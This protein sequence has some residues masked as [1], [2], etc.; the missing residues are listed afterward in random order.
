MSHVDLHLHLLPGVDDGART[1]AESVTHARRMAAGGVTEATV[2][3]HVHPAWPLDL[4]SLPGRVAA[5]REALAAE[6]VPLTLH[7]GGEVDARHAAR[8]GHEDL[9]RVAHGPPGRRW[10]LVETP[11][12]GVDEEFLFFCRGLRARGFGALLAHPERSPGFLPHGLAR[13]DAELSAGTLLQV[14]VCS[15]LGR[16]GPEIRRVAEHLVRTGL[17]F[18]LASDGH[19]GTREHTLGPGEGLARRAG[20]TATAARRLCAEHPRLLLEEGLGR[21]EGAARLA[22]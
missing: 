2:T 3:P 4:A 18:V 8:L 12:G 17:A 19:P 9:E 1:L 16:H 6:D 20:M 15:L 11:W 13:L 14:N 21:P 7:A 5:L 22:S 10:L